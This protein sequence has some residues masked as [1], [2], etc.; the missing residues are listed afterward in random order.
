MVFSP[1]LSFLDNFPT[2]SSG[3]GHS[4]SQPF[5]ELSKNLGS[6]MDLE[7]IYLKQR[8]TY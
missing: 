7:G 4:G 3:L 5:M 6:K 1:F 2:F 8:K